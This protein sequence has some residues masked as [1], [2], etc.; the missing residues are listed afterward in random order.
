MRP[1][2]LMRR[3]AVFIAGATFLHRYAILTAAATW[4]LLIVGSLVTSTDS[5]LAV[6]DWPLSYG[7]WFPPMVGGIL[8]EHGHR[9]IAG[10][11]GLLILALALWT[12]RVEPRRWVRRLAFIALGA[13][14]VQA[15][16]GGLTVLLLLPPAVSIAHAVLGQTVFCLVVCVAHATALPDSGQRVLPLRHPAVRPRSATIAQTLRAGGGGPG[17]ASP[18]DRSWFFSVGGVALV[19]AS[20]AALQ[21]LFGAIIRHTGSSVAA[22]LIGAAALSVTVIWLV[23][24]SGHTWA[25]RASCRLGALIGSQLLLGLAVFSD[26]GAVALRTA[27][28]ATGAL[29]LAQ[30]VL[31]A[32]EALRRTSP[33]TLL[34]M[35]QRLR[36]YLELTKPRLSV[37][38]LVT[39]GVGCWLG[40]RSRDQL[41]TLIPL[42]L[43]LWLVVGGANALNQWR[44]RIPDG[45]MQRTR[46][47]PLPA[48][49]L[50]PVEAFRFGLLL[51]IAGIVCLG[52]AV[53]PLSAVL[54]AA[55]W[56]L[57]VLIYTP[58]K[59]RTSLCTLV[60]AIPG[61]LPPVI[62]WAAARGTLGLEAWALSLILFCWQLPHFLALAVLYRDDYAHAGFPML[63]IVEADGWLTGRQTLLYGIAL[64]PISLFPSLIGVAGTAYF[65]GAA[66]LGAAFA[67]LSMWT[68][69]ERSP[70]SAQRLFRASV[71]Y[72]PLL[73]ALLALN[74]TPL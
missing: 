8:Y 69:W 58:M 44:E 15:L 49:R 28:V 9:M 6:P 14:I 65:Y 25:W 12:W 21:L 43:G 29:I 71:L 61:A 73:L 2:L 26:R 33:Q 23:A 5:G 46:R 42:G 64:V 55:S 7:T 35:R 70:R 68:A 74:R 20:L 36:D 48:G 13:V 17:S 24:R 39:A 56:F 41:P 18:V 11:V 22:H 1:Q 72:L 32:W 52:L 30:A 50:T 37:L 4:L 40:M 27:H 45:L 57:Y 47:R 66:A 53:H 31:L 19:V 60:G 34:G 62:G 3:F 67:L 16:L 59:R 63:P 38:V 10:F 51:S 54:A